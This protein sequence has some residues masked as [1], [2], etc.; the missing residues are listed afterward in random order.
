M[1]GL[2][3]PRR[4]Y[5]T[6]ATGLVDRGAACTARLGGAAR[7]GPLLRRGLAS[8]HTARRGGTM[9]DLVLRNARIVD[10]T[11]R[12]ATFGAVGVRDG[13]LASVGAVDEGASRE[14]DVDG[15]TVMPGVLDL[16]AHYDAQLFW[17]PM[18]SPSPLHGVTTVVAGN[19]G[20]TLAP[21]KPED[22]DFLTR[23]LAR[24]EAI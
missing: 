15:L 17:D 7:H 4:P 5:A 20:L 23:L 19:C 2:R 11:G 18:L 3:A 13:R 8:A 16:H 24:V 9:L 6:G 10:G 1:G 21:A 12:P 14:L 22:R